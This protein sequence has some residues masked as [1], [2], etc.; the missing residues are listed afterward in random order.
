M[1]KATEE[2]TAEM[3][4]GVGIHRDL[5][6]RAGRCRWVGSAVELTPDDP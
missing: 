1:D 5:R 6:L 2:S 3:K 4:K